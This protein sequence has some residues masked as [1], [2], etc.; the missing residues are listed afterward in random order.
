MNI[1][2]TLFLILLAQYISYIPSFDYATSASDLLSNVD[3][4]EYTI[5]ERDWWYG[6][7]DRLKKKITKKDG[8]I[9]HKNTYEMYC[10]GWK[11]CTKFKGEVNFETIESFYGSVDGETTYAIVCPKGRTNP[12]EITSVSSMQEI[13]KYSDSWLTNEKYELKCYYHRHE[14]FL[15]FYLMNGENYILRL[16]GST[17]SVYEKYRFS[18]DFK[19]I[20]DF[21]LMNREE[22][23]RNKDSHWNNPFPFMALV[24]LDDYLQLVATKFDFDTSSQQ[25]IYNNNKKLLPI[26]NYTQAYFNNFHYNNSFFYFT[27]NDIHDFTS[28]YSTTCVENTNY[29]DYSYINNVEFTNNLESPFKYIN[30]DVEIVE[31]NIM[32][33]NNFIYYKLLNKETQKYYHGIVDILTNKIVWNTDKEVSL[34]IPYVLNKI[35]DPDLGRYEYADAL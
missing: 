5:D 23:D 4:Y 25:S 7:S 11:D 12:Y 30:D 28:G 22:R 14:P 1:S 15:V 16:K 17:L 3:E 6:A 34:F 8:V 10:I 32:Y 29:A 35:T 24:K 21:K 33:N 27:Y 19:E 31:M 13:R 20:Y 26:K 9:T 18:D 2:Y